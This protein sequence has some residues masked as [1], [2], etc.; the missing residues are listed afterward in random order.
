M[1]K[2]MKHYLYVFCMVTLTLLGL[3]LVFNEPIKNFIVHHMQETALKQPLQ[4]HPKSGQFDG[5][6]VGEVDSKD[7][8]K[9]AFQKSTGA[10]GKI[11]IPAVGLKLPIFYGMADNNMIR[12]ACTMRPDET[13][14][15]Q[16]NYTLAGHHMLNESILFGP[17]QN[18]KEGQLIYLTNGDKV[19]IY[20]VKLKEIVSE[21][22]TVWLDN[23]TDQHLITL[24]TCAS[25]QTGETRRIII[26][27]ELQKTEKINKQNVK[28]FS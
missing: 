26:R 6:K 7:V 2:K 12:G 9:A 20:K 10:I 22:Q 27:G 21:Y 17:L 13:M 18:V 19:Y 5:A 4:H 25:G 28:V 11:A 8:A 16:G 1:T 15:M 14:G 3:I 23:N 24:V